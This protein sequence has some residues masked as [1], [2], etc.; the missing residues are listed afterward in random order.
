VSSRELSKLKA[1]LET[2]FNEID[3]YLQRIAKEGHLSAQ[4]SDAMSAN[5]ELLSSLI[6]ASALSSEGLNGFWVDIRPLVRTDSE[7]T[8]A[9][10][11]FASTDENLAGHSFQ[12]C[13]RCAVPVTQ[14][15][16]GSNADHQ[17]TTIGRG[18]SDYSAAIIGSALGADEIEIWTDV[19]GNHVHGPETRSGSREG[20]CHFVCRGGRTRLLWSEGASSEYFAPRDG[21][22]YSGIGQELPSA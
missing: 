15:F 22:G 1:A 16:I 4:M 12:S 17:T 21:E 2:Q 20:T 5:G 13:A 3:A 11:D 19:D 8:R 14:G 7:F 6:V 9:A 10:V 18:G